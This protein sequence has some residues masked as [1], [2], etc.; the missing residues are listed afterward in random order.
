MGFSLSNIRREEIKRIVVSSFKEYNVS[1]VPINGFEIATKMGIKVIPYSAYNEATQKLLHKKSED[2]FSVELVDGTWFI[3]YNDAMGYG[4]INHTIM[5]ELA[6]I[7]LD[8]TEESDLAEAE[9][10][11]F[12][13]YALAPPPLIHKYR[14][15]NPSQIAEVFEISMQAATYAYEYYQKWYKHSRN[16]YT[17]YERR[18]LHL[19]ENAG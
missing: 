2:G 16:T 8:H 5:H 12:A 3:F 1:C 19:F 6:H 13:K 14:L 10:R 4:R 18:L 15:Q 17:E 11:F 7:I 9:A